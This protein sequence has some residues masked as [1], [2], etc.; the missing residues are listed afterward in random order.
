MKKLKLLCRMLIVLGLL[1]GTAVVAAPTMA[2]SDQAPTIK[3]MRLSLWPEYDDPRVLVIYQ[4]EFADAG[5]FPQKVQFPTPVGA[6]INQVCAL[7]QPG[8]E[9]LCQLY[10]TVA[11]EDN[12]LG[13]SYTLPI[14]TYFLEYYWDGVKGAPDK[15]FSFKYVSPYAVEKLFVEV[16]QPLKATN[17][18]LDQTYASMTSDSLGMKYYNYTFTNVTPGQV[19][20]LDAAYTKEDNKPSVKKQGATGGTGSVNTT[21]LVGIGA[22][23]LVVF[24]IGFV[25]FKRKPARAPVRAS[26]A[27]RAEAM[28]RAEARRAPAPEPPRQQRSAPP[29]STP[30]QG[31]AAPQAPQGGSFCGKCGTQLHPGDAFCHACGQKARRPS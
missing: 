28:R 26:Q 25:A 24:V 22:A 9:H 11:G 13:I 21:A 2:A 4:G 10:D 3:T 5:S 8:N 12:T 17:F 29:P 16:Q 1:A 15:S 20:S 27:R 31:A 18:K 7:Q 14:P 19:I 30:K 23:A 6:E